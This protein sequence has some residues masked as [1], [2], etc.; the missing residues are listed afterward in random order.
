LRDGPDLPSEVGAA[1]GA[2]SPSVA[3][4]IPGTGLRPVL[5]REMRSIIVIN[6]ISFDDR[7]DDRQRE[8]ERLRAAVDVLGIEANQLV[9]AIVEFAEGAEELVRRRINAPVDLGSGEAARSLRDEDLEPLRR[10]FDRVRTGATGLR[11][12]EET[13]G[14]ERNES[15]RHS[16][17]EIVLGLGDARRV[18]VS[19]YQ[20]AVREDHVSGAEVVTDEESWLMSLGLARAFVDGLSARWRNASLV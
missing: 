12:A 18:V 2:L 3:G 9:A 13:A 17:A 15:R 5:K 8:L 7:D 14:E 20:R 4:R 19:A 16:L 1:G 6:E 10:A 11:D